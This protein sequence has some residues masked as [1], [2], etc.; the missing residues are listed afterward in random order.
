MITLFILINLCKVCW[1]NKGHMFSLI[2]LFTLLTK[3]GY[4]VFVPVAITSL[5]SLRGLSTI[6]ITY[7]ETYLS[8]IYLFFLLFII[9]IKMLIVLRAIPIVTCTIICTLVSSC[10]ASGIWEYFIG[11]DIILHRCTRLKRLSTQILWN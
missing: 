5:L 10:I 4:S 7:I 8:F 1:S 9:W 6:L 11:K 3:C 2:C